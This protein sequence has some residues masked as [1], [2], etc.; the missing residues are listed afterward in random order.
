MREIRL[1]LDAMPVRDGAGVALNRIFGYHNKPAFDPFLMLDDF[2]NDDPN[3]YLAGFPMHPHRG[4]ETITYLLEG[5]AE[6]EDSLGNKGTIG[7]GDI[8]WMT[9]GSGIIHQEM[10]KPDSQGRMYGFQLWTNLPASNKMM[11]PRYQDIKAGQ[12]PTLQAAEGVLLKLICGEYQGVK[13]P[14]EDIMIDPQ[15]WDIR[16]E[17]GTE[18]VIPTPIE[19]TAFIYCYEGEV[20]IKDKLLHKHQVV[21][22]DN[23][24][25]IKLHTLDSSAKLLFCCGKALHE[26]IAWR[27]PI[28]MNTPGE[29]KDAFDELENGTFIR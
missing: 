23:G 22:F 16:L 21:L 25:G 2:S 15:Y 20:V 24:P 7:K 6:H 19:Y 17:S 5:Y 27:G 14:V 3:N 28:V 26:P 29:I 12:I 13:G 9:A 11:P 1:I 18:F 8:Q 10:P 4:I